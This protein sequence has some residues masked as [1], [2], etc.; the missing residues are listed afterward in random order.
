MKGRCFDKVMPLRD[1]CY[2]VKLTM[3][4][5]LSCC[6]HCNLML[7]MREW[8][9]YNPILL[10]CSYFGCFLMFRLSL[11]Q[12]SV[13]TELLAGFATFL[14]MSYIIFVN[15]SVLSQTGMDASA[16][17]VA[18]C[19]AAALGSAMMGLFAN[20]PIVLA[21]GM[22]LNAYFTYSVVLG[23]GVPWQTALG[24]VFISGVIFLGLS[25]FPIREYIIQSIPRSQKIAIVAG[26]GLFLGMIGFKNAGIIVGSAATLTTLG[27][28]HAPETLLAIVGFFLM[29]AL[30]TLQI[31]G[32]VVIS[33]LL[34]TIVGILLGHGKFVGIFSMPPSIF[35]VFFKLDI[36][37]ALDLGLLTIVFAFLFVD[38]FDNTGT[39]MAIAHRAGFMDK[40]TGKMPRMQRVLVADSC[41]AIAGA[42][43]GTSTTTSYVESGVGVRAGGRT[44]LMAVVVSALFLLALFF[45]PL[46]RSVPLYAT[47]P[48]L[49][50]VA[51]MM[52]RAFSELDFEDLTECAPAVMT[53]FTMPLAFSVS[54]G[55]AFGLIS[56]VVI[57]LLTG[58]FRELNVTVVLLALA[59]IA[60]Y[61]FLH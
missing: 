6:Y 51:C 3:P 60:R 32:S 10:F 37:G 34:I 21:P 18:T 46:A 24:A 56:W 40:T 1:P 20:Y 11:H 4:D 8:D 19:L 53:A 39:L 43:L 35:P 36:L 30:D 26:I 54:E 44:G 57:K 50:Y 41:A 13:K 28:L 33:I 55:I 59:F 52:V 23:T 25:I 31:K 29:I 47:A 48:A 7:A 22:G 12:T 42:L 16:V 17:F 14:A 58:R 15:P 2:A 49:V 45:S 61:M 27:N 38:F 5:Y 9:G